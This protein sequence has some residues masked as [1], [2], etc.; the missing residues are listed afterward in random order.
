MEVLFR[1]RIF[2]IVEH[3]SYERIFHSL[4]GLNNIAPT[5]IVKI[6]KFKSRVAR[7]LLRILIS[8]VPRSVIICCTASR[9]IR[10]FRGRRIQIFHA[11]ASFGASW[12]K[13]YIS[14][15]DVICAATEFQYQQLLNFAPNKAIHRLGLPYLDEYAQDEENLVNIEYDICYAP[16]YHEDISSIFYFLDPLLDACNKLKLRLLIRPHPLLLDLQSQ[17]NS[18]K[19]DWAERLRQL[20]CKNEVFCDFSP[21]MSAVMRSAAVITDVSGMAYEF[22]AVTGRP[23]GFVGRKLKVPLIRSSKHIDTD[24]KSIPE[25]YARG[26]IGPLLEDNFSSAA[27]QNFI[28]QLSCD[29]YRER[30]KKFNESY[31]LNVGK[32]SEKFLSIVSGL[33]DEQ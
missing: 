14:H 12:D 17:V 11:P 15:F 33:L 27:T 21:D 22:S 29:V 32:S 6:F 26:F 3:S 23:V 16:T 18:G 8:S 5:Y 10:P 24:Y 9:F 4:G 1:T 7:F 19:V 25:V 20:S 28:E 13:R 31:I 30:S 2:L